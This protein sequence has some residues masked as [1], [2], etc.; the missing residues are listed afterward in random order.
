MYQ[1]RDITWNTR[2]YFHQRYQIHEKPYFSRS[3]GP[4][5]FK[6]FKKLKGCSTV[7]LWD[8]EE[9]SIYQSGDITWNTNISRN[10]TEFMKSQISQN[11][12]FRFSLNF[13]SSYRA[14]QWLNSEISEK[15]E[16]TNLDISQKTRK[17]L[18]K[19]ACY[20][21]CVCVCVC[22]RVRVRACA[23]ACA[24]V[25]RHFFQNWPVRFSDK[26]CRLS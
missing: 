10:V 13:A 20:G 14:Q 8:F 25:Q 19:R 22:A 3:A 24:R 21:V 4:I 26:L 23:C 18:L 7:N 6:F 11:W 1:T 15:F 2:K 12:P 9:I 17:C 5:I 16:Y